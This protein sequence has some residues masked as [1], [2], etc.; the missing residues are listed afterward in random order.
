MLRE[1]LQVEDEPA[2]DN[3][4]ENEDEKGIK[5]DCENAPLTFEPIVF[6]KH[7]VTLII[8]ALALRAV[9]QETVV[10]FVV[11]ACLVGAPCFLFRPSHP[12]HGGCHEQH[13][14]DNSIH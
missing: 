12:N 4:I 3:A 1:V 8:G 2:P 14:V 11:S 9:V 6:G 10:A 7:D 5:A 13:I